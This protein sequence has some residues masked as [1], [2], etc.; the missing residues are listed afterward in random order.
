MKLSGNPKLKS[1][2]KIKTV[3]QP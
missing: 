1:Y 3:F 2:H